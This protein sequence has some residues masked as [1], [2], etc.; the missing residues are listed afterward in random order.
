VAR[1]AKTELRKT[2][3]PEPTAGESTAAPKTTRDND[4]TTAAKDTRKPVATAPAATAAKAVGSITTPD[5]D[6]GAKMKL[7]KEA[8]TT[9]DKYLAGPART[10]GEIDLGVVVLPVCFSS[11]RGIA[12][13]GECRPP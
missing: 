8:N 12:G 4:V 13:E 3:F 6:K 9:M 11:S 10:N 7:L 2:L 5:G 1:R